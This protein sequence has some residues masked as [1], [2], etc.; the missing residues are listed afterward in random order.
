MNQWMQH[1]HSDE[2]MFVKRVI[3][4]HENAL[5][6][7]SVVT[8]PFLSPREQNIVQQIV[9][10]SDV[11]CL[12]NG[13]FTDCERA[14]MILAPD[15]Y[16][17]SDKD[18]EI[19]SFSASYDATW[20]A[21]S[22]R[23]VLGALLHL[24]GERK[25]FGDIAVTQQSIQWVCTKEATGLWSDVLKVKN[26]TLS[27]KEIEASDLQ[28]LEHKWTSRRGFVSSLRLDSVVA[29][30]YGMSRSVAQTAIRKGI[31]RVNH[32]QIEDVA[33]SLEAEDMV[34]LQGKGRRKIHAIEGRTKKDNY[35]I[36]YGELCE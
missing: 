15:W 16:T 7:H 10:Q 28:E 27:P 20:G 11:I 19:R 30:V 22:H 14:R 25:L 31:V 13:G 17:N 24:G 9:G 8:T 21:L 36:S 5:Y 18:W 6:S 4:W 32:R 35:S 2:H 12:K 3:E 29:E 1:F 34:S 23:D 26:I 33:H